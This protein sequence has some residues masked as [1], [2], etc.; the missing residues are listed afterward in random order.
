MKNILYY[1]PEDL[2]NEMPFWPDGK[3]LEICAG[4]CWGWLEE[5]ASFFSQLVQNMA[6]N[7]PLQVLSFEGMA[8]LI[9]EEL[10]ND[11]SNFVEGGLAPGRSVQEYVFKG[12]DQDPEREAWVVEVC[13]LGPILLRGL[14]FLSTGELRRVLLARLFLRQPAVAVFDKVMD[15]LDIASRQR[16]AAFLQVFVAEAQRRENLGS[17]CVFIERS[18]KNLPQLCNDIWRLEEDSAGPGLLLDRNAFKEEL[19]RL[20]VAAGVEPSSEAS[21]LVEM[22]D[23]RVGWNGQVV[24][25]GLNWTIRAG[26]HWRVQGPNGSGKTSLLGLINGDNPQ[27]F[28]N[29]VSIFGRRRGSGES[30]WDI[31]R[32]LGLVSWNLHR[33]YR[34]LGDTNLLQVLV[35]GLYDSIGLYCQPSSEALALAAH[36]LSFF[37][38]GERGNQAFSQ[39]N[40]AEQRAILVL[41]SLIKMPRLLLLDEPC[42][43]L[44]A[45]GRELVLALL[46]E[47]ASLGITSIVHVSHDLDEQIQGVKNLLELRPAE[48]PN[49]T[50]TENDL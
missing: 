38:F 18:E 50:I 40:W 1:L 23:I 34:N 27:A 25:D 42:Q 10:K 30:I 46:D 7:L 16:I 19:G 32:H 14:K 35:S 8:E 13:A 21:V 6:Q 48:R 22:R 49:Y 37:G 43:G 12:L 47:V 31:K 29:N 28:S 11:D 24:L 33:D 9:E 17:A 39:L 26:Q 15:A 4:H 41:R 45:Q 36:W 44:D 5:R 3:E 2:P 20:L